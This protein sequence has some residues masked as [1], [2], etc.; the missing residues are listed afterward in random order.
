MKHIQIYY[1]PHKMYPF[2]RGWSLT[3][4][5]IGAFIG[6]ANE[7]ANVCVQHINDTTNKAQGGEQ[8]IALIVAVFIICY[9]LVQ[10]IVLFAI[11]SVLVIGHVLVLLILMGLALLLIGLLRSA[12][13]LY[14][15]AYGIYYRCPRAYCYHEMPVPSFICPQCK[16]LHSRLWP[17]TYGIFAHRCQCGKWLPT[18][19][20]FGRKKL[21]R[22]CP[23]C[24]VELNLEYGKGTNIDIPIIG[25]PSAGKTNYIITAVN[26]FMQT[27]GTPPS[28]YEISFTE[29]R[30]RLHFESSIAQLQQGGKLAKTPDLAPEAYNL[31]IKVPGV[32]VP[33]LLFMYDAAGETF[34]TDA[35]TGLQA[36]YRYVRGIIFVVD[37]CAISTYRRHHQQEIDPIRGALGPSDLDIE[38][39][40]NR[41]L[42]AVEIY[43]VERIAGRYRVPV[44]VVM[45]KIDALGL[46]DEVGI[47]AAQ[48]LLA[49]CPSAMT[50]ED[51]INE[52]VQRFLRKYGLS[53]FMDQ[54]ESRFSEVRY[55]SCSALGRLPS[56]M[57][58]RAFV[59]VHVL[60]PLV[61]L[62][63]RNGVIKQ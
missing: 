60:D 28:N 41:M 19:H 7:N 12:T 50:Q 53:N 51:A 32:H 54:L 25:G 38:E 47:P 55:F 36:Y 45:T 46:E 10:Y 37:P 61:W 18:L 4:S 29:P 34:S 27:Y 11:M 33:K 57:D 23:E 6:K 48:R 17:N 39:V 31:K 16:A 35:Y 56:D 5:L 20:L 1:P 40:C 24:R 30:Q 13:W 59:S 21:D 62:L 15:R 43:R 52:L 42:R 3:R 2:E 63:S 44:A 22:I 8:I 9:I 58:K 26:A 49:T 14:A